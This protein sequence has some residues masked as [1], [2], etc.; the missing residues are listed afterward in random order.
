MEQYP[1][2]QRA[3]DLGQA[4]VRI[5]EAGGYRNG[6]GKWVDIADDVRTS[7]TGTVTYA[8]E[9]ELANPTPSPGE[10]QFSVRNR[11]TLEAA[12]EWV[13]SGRRVVALN[14]AS[15]RN[16]G[17]GFLGGAR[18]QEESLARSSA[19]YACLNGNPMYEYHRANRNPFYSDFVLY[20]PD[21]PVFR[22]D[23]GDL[24]ETPYPCSFLTSPAVNAGVVRQRDRLAIPQIR[25]VLR[26]RM[27]RVLCAAAL[28]G[29]DSL[30]L[31]A[32]GCGV[33]GN[34]SREVAELFRDAL[35]GPFQGV[36]ARVEF[37]VLDYS[38]ARHTIGPFEENFR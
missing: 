24:L 34:D 5:L 10:T 32:W 8:P 18:A 4:T 38:A 12:R 6:G 15:A 36:F 11:T 23:E 26:E 33:F 20:S 27:R 29:H 2:R 17:G 16:P 35:T 37:A 21:V 28:H 7:V 19:L 1:N 14:F 25:H 22:T 3:A 13:A 9:A 31:G 30:I